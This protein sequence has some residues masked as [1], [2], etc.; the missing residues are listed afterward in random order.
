MVHAYRSCSVITVSPLNA[1]TIAS[2]HTPTSRC[3]FGNRFLHCI[4]MPESERENECKEREERERVCV[5]V[6]CESAHN[7][8]VWIRQQEQEKKTKGRIA[9]AGTRRSHR[10]WIVSSIPPDTAHIHSFVHAA[11]ALPPTTQSPT[12]HRKPTHT[13]LAPAMAWFRAVRGLWPPIHARAT[14]RQKRRR[15]S[16]CQLQRREDTPVHTALAA[17]AGDKAWVLYVCAFC[18]SHK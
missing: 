8:T 1:C 4:S 9:R 10:E 15:A 7:A 5:C 6:C 12:T 17:T 13:P 18:L 16:P 3:T 14:W 2:L 11:N